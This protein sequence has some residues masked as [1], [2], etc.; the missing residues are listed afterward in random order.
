MLN[1]HSKRVPNWD[2]ISLSDC[3]IVDVDNI[4]PY[5]LPTAAKRSTRCDNWQEI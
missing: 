2:F 5:L 4:P 1:V 3:R